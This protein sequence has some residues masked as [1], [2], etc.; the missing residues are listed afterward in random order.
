MTR[1]MERFLAALMLAFAGFCV[2]QGILAH[3]AKQKVLYLDQLEDSYFAT[4]DRCRLLE[5]LS[6]KAAKKVYGW[7]KK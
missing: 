2:D 7:G 4:K 6:G 3:K 5:G 1:R